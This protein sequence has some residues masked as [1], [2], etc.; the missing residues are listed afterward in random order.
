[1]GARCEH[2]DA[3][4]DPDP[5]KGCRICLRARA[6]RYARSEKG[7]AKMAEHHKAT[8]VPAAPKTHCAKGHEYTIENTYRRIADG[9]R[10]CR[11]CNA[12]NA[13]RY[14]RQH[15]ANPGM[16][17][18]G[19]WR[20]VLEGMEYCCALCGRGDVPMTKDHIVPVSKGGSNDISN[21][22]PL[23]KPCNSGKRDRILA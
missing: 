21:I 20:A 9:F 1:M 14:Y 8:Y 7:K 15:K 12:V 10:E 13:N 18:E 19:Q 16:H 6:L 11:A 4:R 23:C 3:D 5:K 2:G 17:T 22:Q